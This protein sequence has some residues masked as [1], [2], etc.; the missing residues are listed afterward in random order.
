M[1]TMWLEPVVRGT[2]FLEEEEEVEEILSP[3]NEEKESVDE[4]E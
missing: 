3:I 1:P 2:P 4:D